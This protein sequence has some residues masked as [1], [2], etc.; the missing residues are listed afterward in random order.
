MFTYRD[1]IYLTERHQDHI[2]HA[3]KRRLVRQPEQTGLRS[4]VEQP[5]R[6]HGFVGAINAGP[7]NLGQRMMSAM[8]GLTGLGAHGK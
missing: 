1:Y 8:N 3:E 2:A 4:T 6:R 5:D 7:A